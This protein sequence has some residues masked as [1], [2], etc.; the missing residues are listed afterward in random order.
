MF[1]F[2]VIQ[3][4]ALANAEHQALNRLRSRHSRRRVPCPI[5]SS[6][7]NGNLPACHRPTAKFH[8][9]PAGS[10]SRRHSHACPHSNILGGRVRRHRRRHPDSPEPSRHW[11]TCN[12]LRSRRWLTLANCARSRLNHHAAGSRRH[13][14][15]QQHRLGRNNLGVSGKNRR[16][17]TRHFPFFFDNLVRFTIQP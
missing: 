5:R 13:C 14:G 11:Q 1:W 15:V 3:R 7:S 16:K 9:R 8:Q 4:G 12:Q 6:W 2:R 17:I 10:P